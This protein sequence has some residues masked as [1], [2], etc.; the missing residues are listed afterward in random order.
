MPG[1][2]RTGPLGQ[3]PLTGKGLGLCGGGLGKGFGRGRGFGWRAR[4]TQAMPIQQA[5]PTVITEK[6]EKEFLEQDLTALKEEMKEIE[7][8]LK[9][10]KK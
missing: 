6:Q 5:Q 4:V 9:E 3:G 10:F 8:R 7:E 1:Q 2:D